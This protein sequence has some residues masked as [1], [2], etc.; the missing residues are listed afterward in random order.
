[1]GNKVMKWGVELSPGPVAGRELVL[2]GEVM[3]PLAPEKPVRCI[4]HRTEGNKL[5]QVLKKPHN[6]GKYDTLKS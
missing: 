2:A 4:G 1:M 3:A 6:C 5:D